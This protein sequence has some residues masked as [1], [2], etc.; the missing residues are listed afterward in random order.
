MEIEFNALCL[1]IPVE[2]L[3]ILQLKCVQVNCSRHRVVAAKRPR[4]EY[5]HLQWVYCAGGVEGCLN[6]RDRLDMLDA[7]TEELLKQDKMSDED[8]EVFGD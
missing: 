7:T 6:V 4:K 3:K 1:S 8:K 2:I 5:V